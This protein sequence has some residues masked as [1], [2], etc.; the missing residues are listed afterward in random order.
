MADPAKTRPVPEEAF[1]GISYL[2][3]DLQ[4]LRLDVREN[5]KSIEA[6]R[7]EMNDR[8]TRIDGHLVQL[9]GRVDKVE[10]RIGGLETRIGDFETRIGGL[11]TRTE[12]LETNMV[13]VRV[14]A[15][16]Q[17]T[18]RHDQRFDSLHRDIQKLMI[19]MFT[20]MI[21]MT[22]V[23]LGVLRMWLK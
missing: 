14:E 9:Q 7:T 13:G 5:R 4:D 3:E 18:Q 12:R 1:W 10:T 2:R 16:E 20:T 11:E 23:I 17:C 8:F 22:G 15:I 6:L 21:A 19:W